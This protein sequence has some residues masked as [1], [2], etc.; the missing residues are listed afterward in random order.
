MKEKEIYYCKML[1]PEI[2]C[3]NFANYF[4]KVNDD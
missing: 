4:F 3:G 1:I 2:D